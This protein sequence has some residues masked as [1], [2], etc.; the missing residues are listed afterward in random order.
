MGISIQLYHRKC[1][2]Y[3]TIVLKQ[4]WGLDGSLPFFNDVCSHPLSSQ[5][6]VANM[7]LDSSERMMLNSSDTV[8]RSQGFEEHGPKL[9]QR[10]SCE[11]FVIIINADHAKFVRISLF[12]KRWNETRLSRLTSRASSLSNNGKRNFPTHLY[13]QP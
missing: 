3:S 4:E 13:R 11:L 8:S 10:K 2:L 6:E 7:C 5:Q 12:K 1:Y 9:K